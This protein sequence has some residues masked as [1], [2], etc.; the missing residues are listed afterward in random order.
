MAKP[1]DNV[2]ITIIMT[3]NS[4]SCV[5][6]PLHVYIVATDVLTFSGTIL[7]APVSISVVPG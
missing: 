2:V 6:I 7:V 5:I 3:T 1:D 4:V